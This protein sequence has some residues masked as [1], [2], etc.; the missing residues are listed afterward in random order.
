M[1]KFLISICFSFL[2]FSN[3]FGQNFGG[4]VT[5]FDGNTYQTII[6]G[7]QEWM[8]ENLRVTH[9]SNGDIIETVMD[10]NIWASLNVG[11]YCHWLNDSNNDII[12]GLHYNW[13]AVIDSRNVCPLGWRVPSNNDWLFLIDNAGGLSN[14]GYNL[15]SIGTI[16]DGNGLWD[17]PNYASNSTGFNVRP[18]GYRDESGWGGGSNSYFRL[19]TS[20]LDTSNPARAIFWNGQN[21]TQNVYDESHE[22][23]LGI[24]LR[25][26]KESSNGLNQLQDSQKKII[27]I[28]DLLGRDTDLKTNTILIYLFDDG[29]SERILINE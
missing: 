23:M 6:I 18:N 7:N 13:Y 9:Y 28:I 20:S 14:A 27:K 10:N 17:S 25:C 5:D 4:G 15:K 11:L 19:W 1:K 24:P 8:A 29:S 21:W 2:I 3:L 16:Q 22:K 12:K 26:I